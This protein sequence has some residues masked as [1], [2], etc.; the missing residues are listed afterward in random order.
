MGLG[1]AEP[2][3]RGPAREAGQEARALLVGAVVEHDE[4]GHRVAVDDAGEGHPATAEL[5]D[6]A[7]VDR[8]PQPEAPVGGGDE[9][10]EQSQL[11]HALHEGVRILVGVLEREC[12]G[13]DLGLDEA[14]HGAD[15]R[16]GSAEGFAHAG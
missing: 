14:A 13:D 3:P 9:R 1:E 11:P 5:F 15:D 12:D 16:M 10:A 8:H 7:R 2:A 4:G 6:D